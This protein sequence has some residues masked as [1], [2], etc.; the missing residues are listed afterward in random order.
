MAD[1]LRV[2][3]A[4]SLA[5][6]EAEPLA[7]WARTALGGVE[8]LRLLPPPNLHAALGFCRR[9]GPGGARRGGAVTPGGAGGGRAR[10][11]R[12]R[13]GAGAGGGGGAPRPPRRGGRR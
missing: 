8:G 4:L 11:R 7:G 13:A 1:R 2:F 9:P 3:V 5:P 6:D 10:P 12:P